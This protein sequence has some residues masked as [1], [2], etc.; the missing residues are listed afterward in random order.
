MRPSPATTVRQNEAMTFEGRVAAIYVAPAEGKPMEERGE[1]QALAGVGL[2]GDRY[3]LLAGKFS[4]PAD[5]SKQAVTLIEREAIEAAREEY[6][7]ELDEAETRRNLVTEGVPVNH[8][9]G[10]EFTVGGI[11]MRG[12]EL[13][14]PCT[15]LESLT[16]DG[17][18]LALIHRG[19]LRAEILDDGPIRV[20]DAV[21]PA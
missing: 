1:V 2:E 19:G 18:R 16:R 10:K 8:L 11:R 14:E 4:R 15:Y 5:L 7:V 3:A 12:D 13:A 21:L 20:G 17:V 6:G 9:L